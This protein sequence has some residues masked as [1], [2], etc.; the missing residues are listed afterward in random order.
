[1]IDESTRKMLSLAFGRDLTA[2]E[3]NA[4]RHAVRCLRDGIRYVPTVPM[5]DDSGAKGGPKNLRK[6]AVPPM[7][8]AEAV[9]AAAAALQGATDLTDAARRLARAGE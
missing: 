8:E 3:W 1:M 6:K 2:A 4:V 7:A 9:L 5:P